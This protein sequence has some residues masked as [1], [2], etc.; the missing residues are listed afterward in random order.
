[1]R[2]SLGE[3]RKEISADA[4]RRDHPALRRRSRRTRRSRSSPTRRSASSGSPSSGRCGCA[5]RS[6]SETLDAARGEQGVREAR[7]SRPGARSTSACDERWHGLSTDATARK[8][9]P[10][11][12]ALARQLGKADREGDPRT[13]L[14]VRDPTRRSS[15]TARASQSRTPTCATTRTSRCPRCRSVARPTRPSGSPRSSTAPPSRTTW[16]PRC[17]RTCPTPGSTTTKT[18][19]GYEIPLTRHFY[20]YV[21]PRPLAEIDAEIKQLEDEIQ[22]LLREVTE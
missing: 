15:P 7:P 22:E 8:R 17:C 4:D 9:S 19:I 16:P 21:P 14:A 12:R 13:P 2:K 5:G 6:P 20:K 10:R 1:M 18:K 3:K 11:S